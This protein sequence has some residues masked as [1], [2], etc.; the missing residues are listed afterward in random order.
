M[1]GGDRSWGLFPMKS[2]NTCV[3]GRSFSR[4]Y[5]Q[6][7][8]ALNNEVS[9]VYGACRSMTQILH[10]LVA[11]VLRKGMVGTPNFHRMS[12]GTQ[13]FFFFFVLFFSFFN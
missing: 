12:L 9:Y 3:L 10:S 11:E 6:L 4:A 7:T 2:N 8:E 5:K 1:K 13:L